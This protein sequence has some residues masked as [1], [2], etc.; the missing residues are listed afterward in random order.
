MHRIVSLIA[1]STEI[2]C[3]LGL[4][5]QLFGVSHECDYPDSVRSLTACSKPRIDIHG[6]SRDIDNRVKH[7]LKDALSVYEVRQQELEAIEPTIIITQTQCEVCAVNLSDVEAAVCDL[8]SSNPKIVSLEPNEL[9]DIWADIQRVADAADVPE[10]GQVLVAEL[11]AEV[12]TIRNTTRELDRPTV[13]CIEWLEPLMAAGNWIPELVDIAGGKNLFGEAG[14]H[15]PWMTWHEVLE[16]DP[17]VIVTM[18]CGFDIQRTM[19]EIH[20]L[21]DRPEWGGLKAVREGRA[22]VSDGNA[23]FNRPGPRVVESVRILTE[24]LHPNLFPPNF[25]GSGWIRID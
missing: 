9:K 4:R 19:E 21:T 14:K 3:R 15:S 6:S 17:D 25:E 20:L 2:V 23:Y 13:A 16:A 11:L 7:A 22:F 18:P 24:V 1:S 5:D 12:D 8:L 10:R